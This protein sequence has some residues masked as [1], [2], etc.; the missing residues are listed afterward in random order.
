VLVKNASGEIVRKLGQEY[1]LRGPAGKLEEISRNPQIYSRLIL[2]GP[3]KYALDGVARDS[4][5]G[6]VS[7]VHGTFEVPAVAEET[8][9][10]SSV[11][12]S[13]GVNP[14]TEEQK[15]ETAHPLYLEG[16]AYLVP[17]VTKAFSAGSDKNMLVH[18]NVYMPKG[19]ERKVSVSLDFYKGGSLIAESS[20]ALPEADVTGRIAYSTSFVLGAFS[21]GEYE[22]VVTASDGSR[23]TSSASR[24][25][26]QP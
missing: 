8:M 13:R 15:R 26:V 21:P 9:G 2:L 17:N 12:L 22:L 25:E 11:V 5:S 18:F 19:L 23:K 16:Q 1:S 7:V 4:I 24:F 6:K 10:M 3:G 14:L 20:G